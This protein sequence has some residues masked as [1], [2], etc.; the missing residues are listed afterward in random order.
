MSAHLIQIAIFE[1]YVTDKKTIFCFGIVMIYLLVTSLSFGANLKASE[2]EKQ[3]YKQER[4]RIE[5]LRKSFTP[6]EY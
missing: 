3:E 4:A 6:E 2:M 1:K 5:A